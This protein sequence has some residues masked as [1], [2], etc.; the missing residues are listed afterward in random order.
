MIDLCQ[1]GTILGG[2]RPGTLRS[3]VVAKARW[4]CRLDGQ[5]TVDGPQAALIGGPAGLAYSAFC[6]ASISP[7]DVIVIVGAGAVARL[8]EQVAL[9]R[10]AHPVRTPV[11]ASLDTI[12]A[13]L[14]TVHEIHRLSRGGL[15]VFETTATDRGRSLCSAISRAGD[16]IVLTDE[17]L[18]DDDTDVGEHGTFE[19]TLT[20]VAIRAAHPDLYPEVAA[21]S[22]KT[23]LDIES[24]ADLLPIADLALLPSRADRGQ[25]SGRV[26]VVMLTSV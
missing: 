7:G 15:A 3:H 17:D 4:L 19:K 5:L 2:N 23:E 18:E 13:R 22:I 21:M 20:L 10:G 12:Q 8:L 11:E 16:V 1:S 9:A 14:S 25:I 24:T 6:R 26:P